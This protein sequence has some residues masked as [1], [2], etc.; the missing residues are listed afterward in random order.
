MNQVAY[1]AQNTDKTNTKQNENHPTN[2]RGELADL[3]STCKRAQQLTQQIND[4]DPRSHPKP[5]HIKGM[6]TKHKTVVKLKRICKSQQNETNTSQKK[7]VGWPIC[8][9]HAK[10][11]NSSHRTN[12]FCKT[13]VATYTKPLIALWRGDTCPNC[14]FHPDQPERSLLLSTVRDPHPGQL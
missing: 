9:R 6:F 8:P 7:G 10:E 5:G 4:S 11:R 2:N 14:I 13:I 3:P 1:W 12:F